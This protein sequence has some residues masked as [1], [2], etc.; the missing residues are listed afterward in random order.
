[1]TLTLIGAFTFAVCVIL[2]LFGTVNALFL[3]S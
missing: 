2:L 3:P 1:M